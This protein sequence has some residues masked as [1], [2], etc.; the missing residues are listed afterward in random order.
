MREL[1]KRREAFESAYPALLKP[2]LPADPAYADRLLYPLRAGGKRLRPI[3]LKAFYGVFGG[4]G[5]E[6]DAFAAAIECI[7]TY[8][9]VHD[10]LPAM[11]DDA[12]RRGQP[13]SHVVY[14]EAD[15]IL[16]GDGLLNLSVELALSAPVPDATRQLAA[17]E[18]LFRASGSRGMILGQFLDIRGEGERSEADLD[19]INALKTGALIEAA[20]R[21][22]AILGGATEEGLETASAYG[23]TLGRA[24]QIVDDL[25]DIAGD[26]KVL[27]KPVG[28]DLKNE[29]TTYPTLLGIEGARQRVRDLTTEALGHLEKLGGDPFLE[30]LTVYL[31]ERDA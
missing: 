24:F 13:T 18:T 12:L 2:L 16:I 23:R 25:L 30:E 17:M 5:P 11:D 15:A 19:R 20:C 7:H 21:I 31:L 28:S 27:G 10:D 9:L 4:E 26:E 22:G 14:G 29:K 3:L 1:T 6:A 8:S